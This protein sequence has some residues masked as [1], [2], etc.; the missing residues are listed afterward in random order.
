MICLNVYLEGIWKAG[1]DYSPLILCLWS[2]WFS[3]TGEGARSTNIGKP[4][5]PLLMAVVQRPQLW[6]RKSISVMQARVAYGRIH[7]GIFFIF[8]FFLLME[9]RVFCILLV[10]VGCTPE[11]TEP[12]VTEEALLAVFLARRPGT[13]GGCFSAMVHLYEAKILPFLCVLWGRCFLQY[14]LLIPAFSVQWRYRNTGQ[15]PLAVEP[16]IIFKAPKFLK[17]LHTLLKWWLSCLLDLWSM[18]G[19]NLGWC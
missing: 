10:F 11:H 6:L 8:Y 14:S 7:L 1:F 5:L 19:S 4:V 12:S 2:V 13:F 3:E 17:A 9:R 18:A 16:N 15:L